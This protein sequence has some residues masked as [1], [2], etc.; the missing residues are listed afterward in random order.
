MSTLVRVEV[1]KLRTLRSVWVTNIVGI[2]AS[3][4]LGVLALNV[5]DERDAALGDVVSNAGLVGMF[6]T[7]VVAIQMANEYQHRTI[8]TAFT[9]APSRVRVITAKALA[10]AAVGAV[11]SALFLALG[12]ALAVIW[13]GGDL[14]WTVGELLRSLLGGVVVAATM[15]VGGVAFGALTRSAGGAVAATV[16]VYIVLETML[17]VFLRFYADYGI[18]AMQLTAMNPFF[19]DGNYAYAPALALNL[20]V[21]LVFLA[22]AIGMVRR[23]DV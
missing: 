8:A 13:F 15:A 4:G 11:L 10:A 16:V 9:L 1:G 5:M 12:L 19:E 2:V 14:P 22:V 6:V 7:I 3:I 23:V 21:A 17:G 20:G 18:S